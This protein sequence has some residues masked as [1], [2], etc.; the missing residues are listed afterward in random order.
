MGY[1]EVVSHPNK[2]YSM[3]SDNQAKTCECVNGKRW[4]APCRPHMCKCPNGEEVL[5]GSRR[6]IC[7]GEQPESCKCE[8]GTD[9]PMGRGRR[10]KKKNRDGKPRKRS[11][12]PNN[13]ICSS[14]SK[15]DFDITADP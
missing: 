5:F 12:M 4:T 6:L 2:C 3:V 14:G 7:N 10:Q 1:G 8:D 11:C 9:R 13:C 15:I